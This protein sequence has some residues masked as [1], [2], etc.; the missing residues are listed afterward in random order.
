MVVP[1]LDVAPRDAIAA[2]AIETWDTY[3]AP[4]AGF[5]EQCHFMQLAGDSRGQ[6]Q[7][8][9]RNAHGDK[10]LSLKFNVQQLPCFTVWKNTQSLAE[11]YVTGLEP[12]VNFPN[13]RSYERGHQRLPIVAPGA[14][15][16]HRFAW[17]FADDLAGVSRLCAQADQLHATGPAIVHA[18]PQPGWSPAGD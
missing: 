9:L 10:G 8:L 15:R 4:Q 14:T 11:G 13:F 17:E 1:A 6:S 16:R 5:V 7:V 3:A 18:V 2:A 12:G